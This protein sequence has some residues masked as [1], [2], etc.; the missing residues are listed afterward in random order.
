MATPRQT[1]RM[2]SPDASS[3]TLDES[4]IFHILGN[5]RRREIIGRI[6]NRSDVVTV[7]ELAD[8]I[9]ACEE[10]DG[11]PTENLYKSVYVSLQQTHL[12]KLADEGIVDYDSEANTVRPGARLDEVQVYVQDDAGRG[13]TLRMAPLVVSLVGLAIVTATT[14][15]VTIAP[16]VDPQTWAVGFLLVI[17]IV[18]AVAV[19]RE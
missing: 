12:P 15:G 5:D 11:E 17:A 10:G 4:Q 9:A 18:S 8:E 16:G 19:V 6:A 1:K 2:D 13:R 3:S 7:S 14:Y